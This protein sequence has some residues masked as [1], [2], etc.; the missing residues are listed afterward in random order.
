MIIF[1]KKKAL[2]GVSTTFVKKKSPK[3]TIASA[4][5]KLN[6]ITTYNVILP[7]FCDVHLCGVSFV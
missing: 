7:G 2:S 6:I 1:V 4:Y 5:I 3:Y